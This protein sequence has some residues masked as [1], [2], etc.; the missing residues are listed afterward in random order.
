MQQIEKETEDKY[1]VT[2]TGVSGS[3][4]SSLQNYLTKHCGFKKPIQFTT[5]QPRSENEVD[6][7][8]F[9]TEKQ[10]MKKLVNGDFSEYVRY[11]DNWYAIS[12]FI[13]DG[14]S[15]L[16]VDPV[17]HQV[18][19]KYA[20]ENKLQMSSFFLDIDDE[21]MEHRLGFLRRDSVKEINLRKELDRKL[22]KNEGYDWYLDGHWDT[23]SLARVVVDVVEKQKA[24]LKQEADGIR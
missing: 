22:F 14:V 15:V 9:L 6:E 5:R 2:L 16:V 3:G 10:F 8:V 21:T 20:I 12:S 24:K 1:L 17:G 23:D 19:K 13:P 4:K 11:R 18:F 7:Y